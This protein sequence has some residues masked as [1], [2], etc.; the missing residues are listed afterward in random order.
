MKNTDARELFFRFLGFVAME[1]LPVT[2]SPAVEAAVWS[3]SGSRSG[4]C[5][6]G[7]LASSPLPLSSRSLSSKSDTVAM[8]RGYGYPESNCGLSSLE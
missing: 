8:V 5:A 4:K 3:R 6:S 1:G 7:P 2:E